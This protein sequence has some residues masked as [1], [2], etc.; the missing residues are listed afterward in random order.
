MYGNS[1]SN[2][3]KKKKF[4]GETSNKLGNGLLGTNVNKTLET[5]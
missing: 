5:C 4:V 3:F 2:V 1:E